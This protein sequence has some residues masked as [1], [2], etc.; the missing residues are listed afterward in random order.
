MG[1]K[2]YNISRWALSPERRWAM[3]P[4]GKGYYYHDDKIYKEIKPSGLKA[5]RYKLVNKDGKRVWITL[6]KIKQLVAKKTTK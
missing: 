3:V 2:P 6:E 1:S 5:P 4:I